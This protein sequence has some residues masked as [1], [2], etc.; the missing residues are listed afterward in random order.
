MVITFTCILT[1]DCLVFGCFVYFV[2]FPPESNQCISAYHI[3]VDD[4][5]DD[6]MIVGLMVLLL[7][8]A[9]PS[10]VRAVQD[11]KTSRTRLTSALTM[12]TKANGDV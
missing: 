11:S 12:E 5:C 9:K 1:L 4:E 8:G 10:K 6:M 2:N 3:R 7:S